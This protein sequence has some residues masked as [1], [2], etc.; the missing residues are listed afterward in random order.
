MHLR[1]LHL[2]EQI[3]LPFN[4]PMHPPLAGAI[5]LRLIAGV[6]LLTI[7]L[8]SM[9]WLSR[10]AKLSSPDSL[11]RPGLPD[12]RAKA[13]AAVNKLRREA[14]GKFQEL[15]NDHEAI[16]RKRLASA[17]TQ[18]VERSRQKKDSYADWLLSTGATLKFAQAWYNN[19]LAGMLEAAT[20]QRLLSR[21]ELAG[22]ANGEA[23][24][25]R[26]DLITRADEISREYNDR[27]AAVLKQFDVADQLKVEAVQLPHYS[28][29]EMKGPAV[30]SNLE[31]LANF[32]GA[33]LVGDYAG[34][35]FISWL[36]TKVAVTA[37]SDLAFADTGPVGWIAGLTVGFAA[38]WAVDKYWIKPRL[39]RELDGQLDNVERKLLSVNSPVLKLAADQA[40]LARQAAKQLEKP[41][42]TQ[43][44][45][46]QNIQPFALAQ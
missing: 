16:A 22:A 46:N 11:P 4:K 21:Q 26:A 8:A 24:S 43:N 28:V 37:G 7:G 33:G 31:S 36:G 32:I 14:A 27:I 10:S 45:E 15:A 17:V 44:L 42:S 40:D 30:A 35:E 6:A 38:Q 3:T 9:A 34:K 13:V 2:T 5:G 29:D 1:R 18:C 19:R 25:L 12:L 39:L 23:E 41:F 20:E